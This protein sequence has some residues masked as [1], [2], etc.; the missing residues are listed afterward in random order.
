[1]PKSSDQDSQADTH[2]DIISTFRKELFDEGIL[3]EGDSVGTDDATIE[4]FLRARGYN[5]KKSKDMFRRC[6]EWRKSVEGVGIDELYRQMD[7][8]DYPERKSVFDCW[9]MWFHKTDKVCYTKPSFILPSFFLIEFLARP[10]LNFEFL[11]RLDLDRLHKECSPERHWQSVLVNAESLPREVIPAA[12]RYHNKPVTSV[13]VVVDLKGFGL[14]PILADEKSGS[15]VFSG[16]SRL[17]PRNLSIINA[18]SSFTIIWAAVK[19]WLAKETAEK[20]DILGSDYKERLL[21]L[22]DADSLPSIL[23][24]NC[25]CEEFGG[26][27]LSGAGPWLD[28]RKGWGPNSVGKD[29]EVGLKEGDGSASKIESEEGQDKEQ[30]KTDDKA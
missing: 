23:G 19:P 3:K 20:I 15:K 27:H 2:K 17:L 22:I 25:T 16:V 9:P 4:R 1:M 6:Q 18:P 12:A 30:K 28:G 21:E 29:K 13:F 10:S 5:L 8:F 14:S 24:G 26:C 11:G 7:P